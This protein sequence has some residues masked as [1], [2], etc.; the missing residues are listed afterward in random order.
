MCRQFSGLGNAEFELAVQKATETSK[1]LTEFRRN[2]AAAIES[3]RVNVPG[4]NRGLASFEIRTE[5]AWKDWYKRF[6]E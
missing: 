6:E 2:S 4:P 3:H 1:D 5:Q